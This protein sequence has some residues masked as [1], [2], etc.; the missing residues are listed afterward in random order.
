MKPPTA[1]TEG[2]LAINLQVR[3]AL[4]KDGQEVHSL[5][6]NA[7]ND[8]VA[9]FTR[10]N[11]NFS[12]WDDLMSNSSLKQF[13]LQPINEEAKDVLRSF[14][15]SEK[16]AGCRKDVGWLMISIDTNPCAFERKNPLSIL[17]SKKKGS[18]VYNS[19]GESDKSQFCK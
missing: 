15:I 8:N 12:T 5:K 2:I 10:E 13:E 19:K 18:S 1:F 17:Y 14:E 7:I 4:Y 16:Y 9:W 6:F 3:V 11:L